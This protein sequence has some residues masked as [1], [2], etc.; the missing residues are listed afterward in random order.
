MEKADDIFVDMAHLFV[1]DDHNSDQGLELDEDH[2][3]E[4]GVDFSL[5]P[6]GQFIADRVINFNAM[7]QTLAALWRPFI[8][9][10]I[11]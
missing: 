10:S 2:V 3:D 8:G 6:V 1:E 4:G 7:K 9:V 5:S 11:R